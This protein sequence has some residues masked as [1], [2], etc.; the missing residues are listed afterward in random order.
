[1][2]EKLVRRIVNQ[3]IMDNRIESSQKELF[4]YGY[5]LLI[6]VT[7]CT[8]FALVMSI[9]LNK[10]AELIIFS[11][12]F[13]PLRSFAGGYH[14]DRAGKCI[15]L[16]YSV[17]LLYFFFSENTSFEQYWQEIILLECLILIGIQPV[18]KDIK[19]KGFITSKVIANILCL[20]SFAAVWVYSRLDMYHLSISILLSIMIWLISMVAGVRK[21]RLKPSTK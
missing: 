16:S 6:E 18:I 9:V 3:G 11:V 13:V 1:M 17:L 21:C 7:I 20:S 10:I 2:M 19:Y 12:I 8:S 4:C 5:T 15:L 14:A